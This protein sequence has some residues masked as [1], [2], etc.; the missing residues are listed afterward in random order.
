MWTL[1]AK[2]GIKPGLL[3]PSWVLQATQLESSISHYPYTESLSSPSKDLIFHYGVKNKTSHRALTPPASQRDTARNFDGKRGSENAAWHRA[4]WQRQA[5]RLG[6]GVVVSLIIRGERGSLKR[7][8]SWK[9]TG[10]LLIN[11]KRCLEMGDLMVTSLQKQNVKAQNQ[12]TTNNFLLLLTSG[13]SGYAGRLSNLSSL[14]G[15]FQKYNTA[16]QHKL[17]LLSI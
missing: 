1:A 9:K 3:H 16:P 10:W 13:Q 5:S 11:P 17:L 4:K 2:Q 15:H 7:Y 12:A 6:A 14:C 8:F